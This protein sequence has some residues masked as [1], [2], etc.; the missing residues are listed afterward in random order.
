MARSA[1][2]LRSHGHPLR[3]VLHAHLELSSPGRVSRQTRARISLQTRI[4]EPVIEVF[5]LGASV[6]E[7]H[8]LTHLRRQL[9]FNNTQQVSTKRSRRP[10]QVRANLL[11]LGINECEA[12]V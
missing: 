2:E 10:P 6:V 1:L 3:H 9:S 12:S 5:V 8:R 4:A 11:F 7:C